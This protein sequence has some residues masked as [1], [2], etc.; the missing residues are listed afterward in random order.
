MTECVLCT[1]YGRPGPPRDAEVG[2]ACLDCLRMLDEDLQLLGQLAGGLPAAL[3][4]R[5][6][7]GGAG[8]APPGPRLPV[9]LDALSL[10]GPGSAKGRASGA[11]P[12]AFLLREWATAWALCRSIGGSVE[13]PE[14]ATTPDGR[15]YLAETG[16]RDL[17]AWLQ[18][19]LDWAAVYAAELPRFAREVHQ[20]VRAVRRVTGEATGRDARPLGWCP[21]V[22]D[23]G[24]L[25]LAP[26]SV[27]AWADTITCPRCSAVY[28]RGESDW[29]WLFHLPRTLHLARR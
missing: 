14:Y 8:H 28:R 1:V 25:C 21:T 15:I 9:S 23:D 5:S 13:R 29:D 10:M 19:R 2:L 22:T 27:S 3:G 12:P 18:L 17:A 16:V 20:C 7:G 11:L 6:S 24:E 26:L 4:I